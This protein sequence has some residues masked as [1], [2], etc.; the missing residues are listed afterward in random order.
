MIKDR[1]F[2]I[3]APNPT[4]THEKAGDVKKIETSSE[5]FAM[6][7]ENCVSVFSIYNVEATGASARANAARTEE[8]W[9]RSRLSESE[10]FG[11]TNSHVQIVSERETTQ[12]FNMSSNQQALA[13][14][15]QKEIEKAGGRERRRATGKRR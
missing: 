1:L 2:F 7:N 6:F 5:S 15:E 12:R 11:E 9:V 13:L 3:P 14:E 8:G 4:A 10:G